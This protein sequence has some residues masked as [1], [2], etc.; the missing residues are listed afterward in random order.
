MRFKS[1]D[2]VMVIGTG[3]CGLGSLA[4]LLQ[5]QTRTRVLHG[6]F[7][8]LSWTSDNPPEV[9]AQ[10]LQQLAE[11]GDYHRVVE[12][13]SSYLNYLTSALSMADNLRVVC[14]ERPQRKVAVS[15]RRSQAASADQ[16]LVNH[17]GPASNGWGHDVQSHCYPKY[18]ISDINAAIR[19]Y[20][21]EY[22]G[23]VQA[24]RERFPRR[25]NVFD[26]TALNTRAGQRAL[27]GYTGISYSRQ[28]LRIG[29]RAGSTS[30]QQHPRVS[31]IVT[32][33][34]RLHHLKRAL[35]TML[36]QELSEAYEVIVVD[37]GCPQ[38]TF[39][40]C[41]SLDE[42]R[43]V[44][45]R[46]LRG[47]DTF[48][49]SR[50]RNCGAAVAFVDADMRLRPSWLRA[51]ALPVLEGRVGLACAR[52]SG[53]RDWDRSG[54]C[55]VN[56]DLFHRVRGYDETFEGWGMEDTDF[57][58][59]CTQHA[60]RVRFWGLLLSPIRHGNDQRVR[61][62]GEKVIDSSQRANQARQAKRDQVNPAGYGD[63]PL[64]LALGRSTAE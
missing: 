12:L 51:A 18:D 16:M 24:L 48:N 41:Q 23:A 14:L 36:A 52:I 63:A 20:W 2:I 5:C 27:L 33:K 53:R 21:E 34:G 64:Q 46:V 54:T 19:A 22:R 7:P 62:Y 45:A 4:Q 28:R 11:G 25:V 31:V 30:A 40:W 8:P 26:T 37:Y 56:A 3:R 13:G 55:V 47:T 57:Y 49:L 17:W 35:P 50:A 29:L 10:R 15:F 42:G 6:S 1:A 59:R 58:D 9:I 61:F 43:L 60:R 39:A 32:C 44:A 38:Q